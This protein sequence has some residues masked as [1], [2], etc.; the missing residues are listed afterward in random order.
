MS[1][2]RTVTRRAARWAVIGLAVIGLAG[3]L[4]TA[5]SSGA[6]QKAAAPRATAT[7]AGGCF[8]CMTSPYDALPGV[9][10]VT[11]GYC[12]GQEKNPTY[13]QVSSGKTGHFES[14]QIVFDPTKITYKKLLDVFWHNIDPTQADGQFCDHGKQYRTA[15]FYHDE[16]QRRLAAESREA[17][18]ASKVL[19]A[20]IVTQIVI[21]RAFWRAEE[22]HQGYCKTHAESY[23]AYR[24]ECG[25]DQRLKEIWGK[26]APV[27]HD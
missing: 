9:I 12:G 3:I 1:V 23:Q 16:N 6:A 19:K 20:P 11:S 8:W 22:Y 24:A 15:I 7:F 26:D 18:E 17:I 5:R 2:V 21:Y 27:P 25:R 4:A 13:E 14:V 10:S